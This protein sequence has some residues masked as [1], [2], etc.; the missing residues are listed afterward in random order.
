MRNPCTHAVRVGTQAAACAQLCGSAMLATARHS[1]FP[2]QQGLRCCLCEHMQRVFPKTLHH[3]SS[4]AAIPLPLPHALAC[5]AQGGTV[6]NHDQQFKAD[7]LIS[8]GLIERVQ[9]EIQV[10]MGNVSW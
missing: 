8:N 5:F 7:V 1:G 6:V 9:P 3:R 10:G 2:V 4:A